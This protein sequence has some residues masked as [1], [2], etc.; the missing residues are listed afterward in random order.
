MKI[1]CNHPASSCGVPVILAD[2]GEVLDY[3]LG[4]TETLKTLG[5]S[6]KELAENCGY[7]NVR[8]VYSF[9]QG[10]IPPATTLNILAVE[11]DRLTNPNQNQ[12]KK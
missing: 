6:R 9:W 8:S 3:K 1:T 5:W 11:L 7:K 10:V 12:Q 2:D 4:L